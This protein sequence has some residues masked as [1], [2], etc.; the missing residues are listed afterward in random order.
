M[1]VIAAP[2]IKK[3]GIGVVDEYLRNGPVHVIK[4]NK[5]TYVVLGENEYQLMLH[6]LA[7]ARLAA[8]EADLKSGR[9]HKETAKELL[10]ELDR[11]G[12]S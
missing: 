9:F 5:H 4:N 7:D 8:S 1:N 6:D 3:R 12:D 11:A 10:A 2:E